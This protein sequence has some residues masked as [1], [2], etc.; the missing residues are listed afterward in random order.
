MNSTLE[1]T[2]RPDRLHKRFAPNISPTGD[3]C[4]WVKA[5]LKRKISYASSPVRKKKQI[6][7][8]SLRT[9]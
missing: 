7:T 6:T 4:V 3:R 5:K 1:V 2:L 9:L 8:V